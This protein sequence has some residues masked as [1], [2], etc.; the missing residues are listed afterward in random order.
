MQENLQQYQQKYPLP[1]Q[2][3]QSD[4]S[5]H[6][7]NFRTQPTV[8]SRCIGE[9]GTKSSADSNLQ[10]A[11]A[12]IPGSVKLHVDTSGYNIPQQS[13]HNGNMMMRAHQLHMS[14]PGGYP[15]TGGQFQQHYPY[16]YPAMSLPQLATLDSNSLTMSPS[17]Q[18]T[19]SS[20]Y[21]FG[22]LTSSESSL[23]SME[24]PPSFLEPTDP[25][26]NL[27]FHLKSLFP[28]N[29]VRHAMVRLPNEMDP[30]K[31]CR[32]ILELSSQT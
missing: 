8:I 1:L 24:S 26:Y 28:E 17:S 16:P 23:S 25:R 5:N 20:G 19:T 21:D 13:A 31:I 18:A 15:Q 32:V 7:S 29:L 6:P 30:Q 2:P 12:V 11:T 3:Y 14:M 22:S 4:F 9:S 27:Y 10:P